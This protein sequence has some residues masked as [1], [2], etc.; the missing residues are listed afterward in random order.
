M[1]IP[2][3]ILFIAGCM[4]EYVIHTDELAGAGPLEG[5]GYG[6][7]RVVRGPWHLCRLRHMQI[8]LAGRL[9]LISGIDAASM[10]AAL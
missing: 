5:H 9:T 3:C 7:F 8:L 1:S 6:L 2:C 10:Q 4:V